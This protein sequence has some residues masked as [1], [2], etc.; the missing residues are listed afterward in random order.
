MR[1]AQQLLDRERIAEIAAGDASLRLKPRRTV[2]R[3]P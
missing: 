1:F 2:R 3:A